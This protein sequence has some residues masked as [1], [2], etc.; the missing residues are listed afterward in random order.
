MIYMKSKK[1]L[2]SLIPLLLLASCGETTPTDSSTGHNPHTGDTSTST[3]E[4]TTS[5]ESSSTSGSTSTGST[6]ASTSTST[7]GSSTSGGSSSSSTSTSTST[8]SSTTHEGDDW[9]DDKTYLE[10]GS[11]SAGK[12]K[13]TSPITI[14]TTN[15]G[16]DAVKYDTKNNVTSPM[17]YI[18]RNS[19]DDGPSGHKCS[20]QMYAESSGG[21]VKFT[22]T[23]VGLETPYF[24]H[25]DFKLEI[26][27]GISQVNNASD[28]PD[29]GKAPLHIYF[30]NKDNQYLGKEEVPEGSIET[31]TAG[32]YVRVYNE[33][34]YT[35]NVA[36]F[37]VRL[38][39]KPYK[40][41]QCYNI[42]V[43]YI[44]IKSWLGS[45]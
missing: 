30:F 38:N 35:K 5:S 24:T 28:T 17:R 8:S 6:S 33:Q 39:A 29:K 25:T 40:S 4:S 27:I 15:V 14:P 13:N 3:S 9:F 11:Y 32:N 7:G 12:P 21:G 41:S 43:E 23:G 1:L 2:L 36:W 37:E 44:S 34:S 45:V 20:A 10:C 42:G 19:V 16:T 22:Q 18:Y 26:R 31:K